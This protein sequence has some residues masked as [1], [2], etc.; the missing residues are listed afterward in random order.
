[1][2]P[3]VKQWLVTTDVGAKYIVLAPTRLLAKINFRECIGV[4]QGIRRIS[5]VRKDR[6][7]PNIHA[8]AWKD[9]A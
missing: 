1:M 8:M 5:P 9:N 7:P 6:T 3:K 4:L 2:I